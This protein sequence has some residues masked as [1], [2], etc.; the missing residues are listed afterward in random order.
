MRSVNGFL[1]GI[2]LAF[3]TAPGYHATLA[4]AFAAHANAVETVAMRY[5]VITL[6]QM[7]R[8]Q[9]KGMCNE[10]CC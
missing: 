5:A 6:R 4:E 3:A 2:V 1:L 8:L 9:P 7:A 10:H